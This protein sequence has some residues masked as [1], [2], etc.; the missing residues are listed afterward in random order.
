M[1]EPSGVL[2]GQYQFKCLKLGTLK[3]QYCRKREVA[4]TSSL[5]LRAFQ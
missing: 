5:M 4:C 3:N 2:A 1:F